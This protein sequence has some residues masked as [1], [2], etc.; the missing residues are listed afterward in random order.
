MTPD[1]LFRGAANRGGPG[2]ITWCGLALVLAA[3]A[4][5][6]F[7]GLRDLAVQCRVPEPLAPLFPV[8]LDAGLAVSTSMWLSRRANPAAER[9]AAWLTWT[10]LACTV[11]ANAIHQGLAASEVAAPWP[12]AVAVGAVPPA[13]VGAVVHIAVLAGRQDVSDGREI[14]VGASAGPSGVVGTDHTA[15]DRGSETARTLSGGSTGKG[16]Q[17]VSTPA[18]DQ[19]GYSAA[20]TPALGLS[21]A[22]PGPTADDLLGSQDGAAAEIDYQTGSGS[23]DRAAALIAEGAGRR[24]LA[25]E[26][27]ISEHAARELLAERRNGQGVAR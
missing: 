5:L 18:P 1:R 8:C 16:T 3:A 19:Q 20:G 14:A 24:R 17:N 6:S 25:A 26:L 4:V 12:L 10:L 15:L 27:R 22:Q 13:V 23:T 7:S 2:W 9:F 21:Q 11:V